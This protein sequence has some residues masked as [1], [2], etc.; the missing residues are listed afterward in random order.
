MR[1]GMI[2]DY[3]PPMLRR[4]RPVH[5]TRAFDVWDVM[6]MDYCNGLL[7]QKDQ[8]VHLDSRNQWELPCRYHGFFGFT[9]RSKP[10][11]DK[12][13]QPFYYGKY[14]NGA[15]EHHPFLQDGPTREKGSL[16]GESPQST[17]NLFIQSHRTLFAPEAVV[18]YSSLSGDDLLALS[19]S[20]IPF[21]SSD[22]LLPIL[23]SEIPLSNSSGLC[24]QTVGVTLAGVQQA[25]CGTWT[26]NGLGDNTGHP[27]R[28]GIQSTLRL[29]G[30]AG[31]TSQ[32]NRNSL[33]CGLTIRENKTNEAL[34]QSKL[35]LSDLCLYSM[36]N[37]CALDYIH[38]RECEVCTTVQ[39]KCTMG[40]PDL[41]GNITKIQEEIQV[42]L[43]RM[44][45]GT[46]WG[47]CRSG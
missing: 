35:G 12:N 31:V 22:F 33:F 40:I 18:C 36:Q 4:C 11:E 3:P 16:V 20:P 27:I 39:D 37:Q 24:V 23:R 10:I 19:Q 15:R 46:S 34:E 21:Y 28:Y 2:R 25:L 17:N 7:H 30:S 14:F 5:R 43:D 9:C 1:P 6:K 32:K 44:T 42:F 13:D 38:A 26:W 47:N 45:E 8:M 41:T 29:E